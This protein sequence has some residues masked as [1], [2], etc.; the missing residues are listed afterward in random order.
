MANGIAQRRY[1]IP[2]LGSML[3]GL[4]GLTYPMVRIVTGAL[5]I[6]H[7]AQKLFEWFGGSQA[8][9]AKF[10]EKFGFIPGMPYVYGIGTL[11]FFGGI[12][13][14][15]G[16][17]TRLWA[18]LLIGFMATAVFHVL[19]PAGFFWTKGGYEFALMWLVLAVV[20]FIRG[21]GP[22]SIDAILPKQL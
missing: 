4:E 8:G 11:E 2:T 19:A 18:L 14:V 7:G 20:V 16:L 15:L 9:T 1:F 12:C 13:I 10:F 17:F 22:F 5:L 21:G 3:E 6:P